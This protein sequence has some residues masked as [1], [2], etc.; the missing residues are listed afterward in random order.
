MDLGS[1]LQKFLQVVA[2]PWALVDRATARRREEITSQAFPP[3][4]EEILS[5]NLPV[6]RSLDADLKS[7]FRHG[8]QIFLAEKRFEGCQ[9]FEI[10]DE[11]R[12][13]IAAHAC[14]LQLGSSPRYYPRVSTILV[15]PSSFSSQVAV[16]RDGVLVEETGHWSGMARYHDYVILGWDPALRGAR[17]FTDADNPI[18]HEFA[19]QL[20]FEDGVSDG[21]PILPGAQRY[22]SWARV[23]AHEYRKHVSALEHDRSTLLSDYAGRNPAE[24]FA[25]LTEYFFERPHALSEKHPQLY[26][27]LKNFYEVDPLEWSS[28]A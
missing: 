9:G 24:F 27:E 6:Y 15:Y 18:V 21:V 28:R 25:V 8:V 13:T 14:L 22:G 26:R 23:F 3:E 20:D 1:F 10:T 5:T 2:S 11:V 16:S 17:D 12:V 7:R 19:H 4:W